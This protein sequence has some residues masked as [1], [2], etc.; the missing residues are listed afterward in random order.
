MDKIILKP[1]YWNDEVLLSTVLDK[2]SFWL[3]R[4][5]ASQKM[6]WILHAPTH[7]RCRIQGITDKDYY[8]YNIDTKNRSKKTSTTDNAIFREADKWL[9]NVYYINQTR[10]ELCAILDTLVDNN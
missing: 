5:Q 6:V 8:E 7:K 2:P 9:S 3:I 10:E 1:Q 4:S